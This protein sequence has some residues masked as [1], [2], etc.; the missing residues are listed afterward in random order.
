MCDIYND[1][2]TYGLFSEKCLV[3]PLGDN[4]ENTIESREHTPSR[5]NTQKSSH[6]KHH[7]NR[8]KTGQRRPSWVSP[9]RLTPQLDSFSPGAARRASRRRKLL[10][11]RHGHVMQ[12]WVCV[13]DA[14]V[15]KYI[16]F[17]HI[18]MSYKLHPAESLFYYILVNVTSYA[19]SNN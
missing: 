3:C 13:S 6:P 19:Y 11:P 5:H 18:V 10:T 17:S 15:V 16:I 14:S 2:T 1:F 12:G 7:T 9:N 4:L 8:R